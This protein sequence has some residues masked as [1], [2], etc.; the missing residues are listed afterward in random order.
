[1]TETLPKTKVIGNIPFTTSSVIGSRAKIGVIVLATDGTVEN[2]LRHIITMPGVDFFESRIENAAEITPENLRLMEPLI[3]TAADLILPGDALDVVA[4]GCTSASIVMGS[5]VI[6][7]NIH[8]AKPGA[9]TT[10]PA[11]AAFAAFR[12]L[13]A[14]RIGVLT[15][16]GD[17]VNQLVQQSIEEAGFE[18]PVFGS[19][20]EPHDPTVAKIDSES[21]KNGLAQIVDSTDVDAVFISCTSIRV[22]ADV[23]AIEDE[24]GVP[25][26]SSNHAMAWHCLRLAGVN[27]S[28]P[29]HG[30]LF[31]CCEAT[32]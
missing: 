14:K 13:G 5:D 2:E 9:K 16:Y 4:F 6:A 29:E 10:N 21:V 31:T 18:V 23:A 28:L 8:A 12:A 15:P 11:F 24:V 19:F 32:S 7:Q 17:S 27:D 25:V 22:A 3:T 30:R 20:N 26:T 1:M